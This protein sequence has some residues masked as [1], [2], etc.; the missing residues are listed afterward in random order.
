MP[1][2]SEYEFYIKEIVYRFNDKWKYCN[3]KM[4]H[5]LPC[6]NITLMPSPP[7]LPILK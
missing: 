4:R 3:I 7:H 1:E 6:E 5:R 2:L